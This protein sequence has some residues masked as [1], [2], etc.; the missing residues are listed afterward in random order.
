[1]DKELFS[2]T[3]NSY[4][5]KKVKG[6]TIND[7]YL[8]FNTWSESRKRDG[9]WPFSKTFTT[10]PDI[11]VKAHSNYDLEI[12]EYVNF[13]SQD[14]LSLSNHPNVISVAANAINKFGIHSAGSAILTGRSSLANDLEIRLAKIF[15][16]DQCLLFT[17]G[18]MACFGAIAG[19]ATE[20]DYI[21]QD[22]LSHNCL[23]VASHYI[24]KNVSRFRHNDTDDLE[25]KLIYISGKS[26]ESCIF[27][28]TESLFSMNSD[29]PDINKLIE[30]K[31]KY[32]AILIIDIAHDFGSMGEYGFGLL[33]DMESGD[34]ENVVIIG[35][36]SKTFSAN[37][38]FVAGQS[39]IRERLTFFAPTYT[40]SNAIAPMQCAVANKCL[41]IVLSEE[42][43]TLRSKLMSNVMYMRKKLIENGFKVNG[44]PSPIIPVLIDNVS[45]ARIM[46]LKLTEAGYIFNLIEYPAVPKGQAL[47]RL[48]MMAAYSFS[49]LDAAFENFL[50]AYNASAL[51]GLPQANREL[52]P[53]ISTNLIPL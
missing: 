37:G 31:T 53:G 12:F 27:I 39:S 43:K 14:Y 38:G 10:K 42:G 13:G 51:V 25:R 32:N 50:N 49:L 16:T 40:F 29:S 44:K 26:P 47:F 5:Y 18:W 1:M 33:E 35:S 20:G 11:V 30:L 36:F 4:D 28:V 17:S 3:G 9:V 19:L 6:Q 21:L 45:V 41:D 8:D 7:R 23:D 2:L 52:F 24:S 22:I 15:K 46:S 34:L 48:Q